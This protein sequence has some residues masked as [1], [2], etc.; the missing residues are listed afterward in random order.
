[1]IALTNPK[2]RAYANISKTVFSPA[3]SS[4]A[5]IASLCYASHPTSTTASMPLASPLA[6]P[7]DVRLPKLTSSKLGHA[8]AVSYLQRSITPHYAATAYN[9]VIASFGAPRRQ[10]QRGHLAPRSMCLSSCSLST[11]LALTSSSESRNRGRILGVGILLDWN[12][13]C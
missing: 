7:S 13:T 10:I 11:L 12:H 3:S 8:S 4:S 9:A 2:S 1:M 5:W 6:L